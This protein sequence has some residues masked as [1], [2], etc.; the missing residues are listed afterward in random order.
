MANTSSA[1]KKVRVIARKTL[2]REMYRNKIKTYIKKV[3]SLISEK[4]QKSATE[5]LKKVDPKL[6]ASKNKKIFTKAKISRIQ[7]R[8]NSSIAQIKKK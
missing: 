7:K 8:L 6:Q 4:D 1:K 2:S 5:L 3:E